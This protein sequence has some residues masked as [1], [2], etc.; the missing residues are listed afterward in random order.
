MTHVLY[1]WG[2]LVAM[3]CGARAIFNR[4]RSRIRS[5]DCRLARLHGTQLRTE[6]IGNLLLSVHARSNPRSFRGE[7]NFGMI[8]IRQ[9]HPTVAPLMH[10][11]FCMTSH[12]GCGQMEIAFYEKQGRVTLYALRN[13]AASNAH[14]LGCFGIAKKLKLSKRDDVVMLAI[15]R[16]L[17]K[18][19][20]VTGLAD[21]SECIDLSVSHRLLRPGSRLRAI[22]ALKKKY[23][24]LE[25]ALAASVA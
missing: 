3:Y 8:S 14:R 16:Y 11:Y 7:A 13:T 15:V 20:F 23:C 22:N 4:A 21:V 25:T 18:S 2:Y 24:Q 10:R 9:K 19:D 5:G 17:E 6:T 12:F 1:R